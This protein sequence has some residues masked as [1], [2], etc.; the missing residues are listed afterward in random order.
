MTALLLFNSCNSS[1][2]SK[3]TAAPQVKF[4]IKNFEL[5]YKESDYSKSYSG[6]GTVLAV[7]NPDATK[8]PYMVIVSIE[9]LKGEMLRIT[10]KRF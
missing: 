5:K 8:S 6:E 7:G 1:N 9:K 4:E 3:P 10:K 2:V